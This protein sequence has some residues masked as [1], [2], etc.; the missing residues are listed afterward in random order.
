M[1]FLW[2]YQE[3]KKF[4]VSNSILKVFLVVFH[5][6]FSWSLYAL[7]LCGE[8]EISFD[9]ALSVTWAIFVFLANV[10]SFIILE[11]WAEVCEKQ[12]RQEVLPSSSEPYSWPNIYTGT[13]VLRFLITFSCVSFKQDWDLRETPSRFYDFGIFHGPCN[14]RLGV[15]GLFIILFILCILLVCVTL[16]S[17][18][19]SF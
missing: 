19:V 14:V 16:Y 9:P 2:W 7:C 18:L 12:K 15:L 8:I 5:F 11:E 10:L 17:F 13:W 4:Y 6:V 3:M 1:T